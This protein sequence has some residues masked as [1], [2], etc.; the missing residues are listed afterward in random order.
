MHCSFSGGLFS[1]VLQLFCSR[2]F[3]S[4]EHKTI[5]CYNKPFCWL[6]S[7]MRHKGVVKI[8][9]SM[10]D[11]WLNHFP[12]FHMTHKFVT[13]WGNSLKAFWQ[14]LP[15]WPVA[16]KHITLQLEEGKKEYKDSALGLKCGVTLKCSPT[17]EDREDLKDSFVTVKYT[18]NSL[19][20]SRHTYTYK[21]TRPDPQLVG[22]S[23]TVLI[24]SRGQSGMYK[25]MSLLTPHFNQ[26]CHGEE[27]QNAQQDRIFS[28]HSQITLW[29]KLFLI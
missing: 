8:F 6:K 11:S 25:Q 14:A 26:V 27:G 16:K 5:W 4:S 22:V 28:Y 9:E 24:Y 10:K 21:H 19:S 12:V 18:Q 20:L 23:G 15:V 1:Q 7:K 3:P 2:K 29:H 17:T 13:W